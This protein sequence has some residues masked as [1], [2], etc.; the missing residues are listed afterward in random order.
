MNFSDEW[1]KLVLGSSLR[2]IGDPF[3][4]REFVEWC[5][6]QLQHNNYPG[7][8]LDKVQRHLN[9]NSTVLD[10]GAGTGAFA[11]PIAQKTAEVTAI[12]PSAEMCKYL[13][14]KADSLVNIRIINKRWEDIDIEE[15][16]RHDM[17]LAAHSLYGIVDIETALRKMLSA[18]N[19][20]VCLITGVGQV[21]FYADIWQR[22]KQE[23]YHPSP[24]FIH[25][26]NVIFQLGIAANVE[27]V[28]VS[29]NQVYLSIEQVVKSW[30]S[31]LHLGPG[32][33][34]EL[35]AY[36]L[37]CLEEKEGLLYRKE[38]GKS[39]IITVELPV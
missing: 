5:D 13:H 19:S 34:D 16:G 15:I 32:R 3:T 17:V 11:I 35:R 24:S 4:S 9:E 37:S 30:Q 25:L 22:F 29:R 23:E 26:Y 6:L 38:E 1:R 39:A 33:E 18:A 14:S 36:L 31:R 12:E 7:V 20:R 21:N 2:K 10:I 27:M 8:L 28:K